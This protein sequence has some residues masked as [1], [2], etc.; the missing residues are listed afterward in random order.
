MVQAAD[1]VENYDDMFL[2]DDPSLAYAAPPAQA[3]VPRAQTFNPKL[4]FGNRMNHSSR[5]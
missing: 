5:L 4:N 3:S 1:E 2:D